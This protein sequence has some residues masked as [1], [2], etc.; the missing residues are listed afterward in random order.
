[1][2]IAL[3]VSHLEDVVVEGVTVAI[4]REGIEDVMQER[5]RMAGRQESLHPHC[6]F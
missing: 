1:M 6:E 5:A 2:V 4:V 3:S